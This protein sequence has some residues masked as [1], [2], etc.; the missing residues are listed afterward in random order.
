MV[1]RGQQQSRLFLPP[2]TFGGESFQ[3]GLADDIV[4]AGISSQLTEILPNHGPHSG[5][6]IIQQFAQRL[7]S[8]LGGM[9]RERD[10][11]FAADT[12]IGTLH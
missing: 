6:W 7:D 12:R 11:T 5:M 8:F 4:P 10:D 9:G 2:P 1:E 3:G